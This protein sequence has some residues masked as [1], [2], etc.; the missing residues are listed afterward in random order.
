MGRKLMGLLRLAAAACLAVGAV[1]LVV[2]FTMPGEPA[3]GRQVGT[4]QS[5]APTS[6][7]RPSY[8]AAVPKTTPELFPA[9]DEQPYVSVADAS[10]DAQ[11]KLGTPGKPAVPDAN[12]M[13]IS[14]SGLNIRAEPSSQSPSLFVLTYGTKVEAG[15]ESGGWVEIT[16]PQGRNGWAYSKYLAKPGELTG[17][18]DQPS[19]SSTVAVN[20]FGE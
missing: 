6:P 1:F 13:L 4:A 10:A 3:S 5:A 15:D 20:N 17:P 18:T 19:S 14:A 11:L 9:Q 7:S 16:D 2:A 12:A 8:L